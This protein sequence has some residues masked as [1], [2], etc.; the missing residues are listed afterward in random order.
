MKQQTDELERIAFLLKI[1][2]DK[3]RLAML[4][5]LKNRE[6]CVCEFVDLF[7]LTQPAISQH[8]KKLRTAG[9]IRERKQ[10]TWVYYRLN[11]DL[12]RFITSVI[13]EL[14]IRKEKACCS[15]NN[16][17]LALLEH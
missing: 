9:I 2:S 7:P 14:P 4:S 5:Y 13:E 17:N 1:I 16:A 12:P 6:M 3:T 15:G 10:G 11:Q 8:L